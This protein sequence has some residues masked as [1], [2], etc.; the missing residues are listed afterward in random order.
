MDIMEIEI[1]EDGAIKVLTGKISGGNH[2]NAEHLIQ[3]VKEDMG[4][5]LD[6]KSRGKETHYHHDHT[7]EHRHEH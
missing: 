7:H 1:L 3:A 4:G 2:L 6:R 5:K